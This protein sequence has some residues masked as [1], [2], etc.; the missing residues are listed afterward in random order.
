MTSLCPSNE[1][2]LSPLALI[3]PLKKVISMASCD[4]FRRSC[5]SCFAR[6]VCVFEKMS[7]TTMRNN[8]DYFSADEMLSHACGL[9]ARKKQCDTTFK[10]S[11]YTLLWPILRPRPNVNQKRNRRE[12]EQVRGIL[13]NNCRCWLLSA[14]TMLCVS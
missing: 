4:A 2:L 7:A 14:Q 5:I 8:V 12:C 3:V 13:P 10:G 9:I 6:Y 11:P 1:R